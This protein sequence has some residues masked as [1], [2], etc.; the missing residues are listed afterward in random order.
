MLKHLR[1]YAGKSQIAY[2]TTKAAILHFT[3]HTAVIYAQRTSG[4]V[5]L[6]AVV[7]GL[8]DT[9]LLT[10]MA[11]NFA[12]GDLQALKK[13]REKQTP[14]GKM[15]TAWDVANVALFLCSSEAAYV[16]GAELV[17]DG[18]FSVST[19]AEGFVGGKARM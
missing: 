15:G 9:P 18:G 17:V 2:A 11:R 14:M 6:N 13:V 1:R 5:R 3:R 19:G 7:P 4:R 10:T 12:G 8:M 16:T